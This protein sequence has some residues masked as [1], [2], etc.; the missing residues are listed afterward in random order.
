MQ[1]SSTTVLSCVVTVC[2]C[3]CVLVHTLERL[4]G[5]LHQLLYGVA[6]QVSSG[7]FSLTVGACIQTPKQTER[8]EERGR[9]ID[10]YCHS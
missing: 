9:E 6:G 10:G 8:E 7:M 3:V 5:S 2:V 1:S 4:P